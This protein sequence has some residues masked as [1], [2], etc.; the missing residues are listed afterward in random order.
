MFHICDT[1]FKQRQDGAIGPDH[2]IALVQGEDTTGDTLTHADEIVLQRHCPF[3]EL[4]I[5]EGYGHL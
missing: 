4:G 1:P 2:V 3:V 5:F